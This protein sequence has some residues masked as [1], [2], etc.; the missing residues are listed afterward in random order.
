MSLRLSLVALTLGLFGLGCTVSSEQTD[1]EST[2]EA[3]GAAKKCTIVAKCAG[4]YTWSTKKCACVP[5]AGACHSDSECSLASNYCGGCSCD[6]LG[7]NQTA[8][9][10]NNPVS[11]FVD[12]C[13]SKTAVCV[14]L[15]GNQYGYCAA[16]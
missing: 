5:A 13:M 15:T 1:D 2:A 8:T 7:P 14:K 12:P 10:C 4:G 16:Q 11:C 6:A 3:E 9:T